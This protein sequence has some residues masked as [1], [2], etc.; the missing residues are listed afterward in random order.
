MSTDPAASNDLPL[1]DLLSTVDLEPFERDEME[2][3]QV[4]DALVI[5]RYQHPDWPKPRLAYLG[6]RGMASEV[7]LGTLVMVTDRVRDTERQN[8]C[9]DE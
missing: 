9:D 3:A 2:G 5:F 6:T 1:L 4:L 7:R 8:W